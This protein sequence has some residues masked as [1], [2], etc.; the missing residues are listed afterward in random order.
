LNVLGA[1]LGTC[2]TFDVHVIQWEH[3][4]KTLGIREK[5]ENMSLGQK[6]KLDAS[7]LCMLGLLVI[8]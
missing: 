7:Y 5:Y 1:N 6:I 3:D 8:P 2:R 4:K